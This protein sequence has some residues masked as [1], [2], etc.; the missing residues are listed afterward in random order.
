MGWDDMTT[1]LYRYR[2]TAVGGRYN[3]EARETERG[4]TSVHASTAFERDSCVCMQVAARVGMV[5]ELC[6]VQAVHKDA[7][8]VDGN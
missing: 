7:P 5:K 2:F 6:I 1:R 8:K 4:Y 3:K